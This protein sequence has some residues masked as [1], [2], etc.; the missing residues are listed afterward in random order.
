MNKGYSD[1]TEGF[2]LRMRDSVWGIDRLETVVV[3]QKQVLT[4]SGTI[5]DRWGEQKWVFRFW[6]LIP[7][8][9]A[10]GCYLTMCTTRLDYIGNPPGVKSENNQPWG[11]P[12]LP[13]VTKGAVGDHVSE[14]MKA[15]SWLVVQEMGL[16]G[17]EWLSL[18]NSPRRWNTAMLGPSTCFRKSCGMNKGV[19]RK[20][21]V[22]IHW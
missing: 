14:R 21:T 10:M 18:N 11:N 2:R 1:T 5:P 19:R 6:G 22:E 3:K 20:G 4:A 16:A 15:V 7:L 17:V 8:W 13:Q 9:D 12:S